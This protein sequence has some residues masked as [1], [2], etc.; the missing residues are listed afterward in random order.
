MRLKK[1]KRT[2]KTKKHKTTTTSHTSSSLC[3]STPKQYSTQLY[4]K[5]YETLEKWSYPHAA[6]AQN[7]SF[8]LGAFQG[9]GL[10]YFIIIIVSDSSN[11]IED[12]FHPLNGPLASP[13]QKAIHLSIILRPTTNQERSRSVCL[14]SQSLDHRI[15]LSPPL[16]T[17]SNHLFR[18]L[19]LVLALTY[20]SSYRSLFQ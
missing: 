2:T 5:R 14:A 15:V 3:K 12:R 10:F 20:Q 1:E 13:Y 4:A 9:A 11:C 8:L 7:S 19:L 6:V 17:P 16:A 18:V